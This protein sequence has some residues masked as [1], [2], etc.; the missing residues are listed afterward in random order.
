LIEVWI[1]LVPR[2]L[3]ADVLSLNKSSNLADNAL[4]ASS[5]EEQDV[6]VEGEDM[7]MEPY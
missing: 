2:L 3:D 1:S 5:Q 6:A 7:L 4:L